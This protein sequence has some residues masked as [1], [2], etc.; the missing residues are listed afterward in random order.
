MGFCKKGLMWLSL[1]SFELTTKQQN[2]GHV[3]LKEYCAEQ[4]NLEKSWIGALAIAI[5]L[6]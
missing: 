6:K 3:T 1:I 4:G 2:I 5:E